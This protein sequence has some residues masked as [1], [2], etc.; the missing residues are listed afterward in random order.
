MNRRVFLK[1]SALA[2]GLSTLG[3]SVF[4]TGVSLTSDAVR[5]RVGKKRPNFLFFM[6][7]DLGWKDVGFMGSQYYE[8]PNI[9][10][11]AAEGMVFT[12]AYANAANCAPTRASFLT[13]QYTCR[14]GVITV[15]SSKR[16]A[17]ANRRL[18]PVSNDE[19]LNSS[20]VTIAE[21][22]KTGGY[23]SA[24]MG[25]WHMGNPANNLGPEDQGFDLNVGGGATGSPYSGGYFSPYNNPYLTNGPA[26]EYL[27]DRLS[28]EAIDF[29][30]T[31]QDKPFFLYLTH[32]AVHT[33]IQAKSDLT[34]YYNTKTGTTLPRHNDPEYAAMVHSVDEGIGR[35]MKRLKELQLDENTVVVFFSDN[36]GYGPR[37][38]MW[39]LR[40]SKGMFYEGGIREPM[41]VRWSGKVKPGTTCDVPV[42]GTDFFPTFLELGGVKKSAGK[43]LDG[44][45]LVPLLEGN[46]SLNREAIFWHFP[47][48]LDRYG[49]NQAMSEARLDCPGQPG[50]KVPF[51]SRP[52]SVIRKGDW[53]LMLF[54]EEWIL[55][56]NE[57]VNA[58][59][60][61]TA[62]ELY[63]LANDIGEQN[64]LTATN[65]AKRDELLLDLLTWRGSIGIGTGEMSANSGFNP[66]LPGC[67]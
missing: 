17:S 61:N 24:S 57:D 36:G 26:G 65:T 12:N 7:D 52:V 4:A 64:N 46:S 58:S 11:L 8:T 19:T 3:S 67:S 62:I 60:L 23:V 2:A 45:S 1:Q 21:A 30:E 54:L 13:G 25:K 43:I 28:D 42:I 50:S 39:P 66:P 20:H 5:F 6:I 53:K 9:D 40:G 29:I 10:K 37:T 47:A 41:V 34:A 44:E 56:C 31:N 18:I 16:G 38:D 33:P 63:N 51:R 59:N 48:Y 55:D 35:I 49:D 22:L 32:Y 15:G 27:T 14:H